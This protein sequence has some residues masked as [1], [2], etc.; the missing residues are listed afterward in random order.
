MTEE[1]RVVIAAAVA[2]VLGKRAVVRQI[3]AWDH[4]V[5]SRW[6]HQGRVVMHSSHSPAADRGWGRMPRREPKS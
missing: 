2:A 6:A 4:H 1:H 3:R 5:T